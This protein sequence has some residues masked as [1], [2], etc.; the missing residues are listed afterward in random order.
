MSNYI[1]M[2]DSSEDELMHY[3]VLGMRWHHHK[4]KNYRAKAD[5]VRRS[6]K[7]MFAEARKKREDAELQRKNHN[8]VT[9]KRYI[10]EAKKLEKEADKLNKEIGKYDSKMQKHLD[11]NAT[12]AD[13][14]IEKIKRSN[15]YA[16][17]EDSRKNLVTKKQV[18]DD[19]LSNYDKTYNDYYND[20]YN[21]R[22]D[23]G[24]SSESIHTIAKENAEYS[25]AYNS[26]EQTRLGSEISNIEN[27][28]KG[29]TSKWEKRKSKYISLN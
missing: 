8:T 16:T 23:S 19:K 9:S 13:K 17:L 22:K 27:Q 24:L 5:V 21:R 6:Q 15:E 29:L 26:R 7:D 2:V 28:Q 14:K 1:I 3:G 18:I 25:M 4:A 11:K 12:N 20:Q 10:K